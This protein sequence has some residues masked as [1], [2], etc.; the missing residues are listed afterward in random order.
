[1]AAA[2]A[3]PVSPAAPATAAWPA[4]SA[5][6]AAAATAA[7]VA[8]AVRRRRRRRRR[9]VPR[10]GR[11]QPG[12]H[13]RL[14]PRQRLG[15]DRPRAACYRPRAGQPRPVRYRPR[16]PARA[17]PPPALSRAPARRRARPQPPRQ[18]IAG[19]WA[20]CG[21][22]LR[23]KESPANRS[24]RSGGSTLGRRRH[25]TRPWTRCRPGELRAASIRPP[26]RRR[27]RSRGR[28][29]ARPSAG[30]LEAEQAGQLERVALGLVLDAFH[31]PG[32]VAHADR[33][34]RRTYRP[35]PLPRLCL[36]R[37][38]ICRFC[39]LRVSA[40]IRALAQSY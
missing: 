32:H 18:R 28:R 12:A 16:R 9:L 23:Q 22:G 40:D 1:M 26:R 29:A 8:A 38:A 17:A 6:V 27:A 34:R 20:R 2:A 11:D 19:T 31:D 25:F 39:S 21:C 7:A 30:G 3:T 14:Q 36:A 5:V 10:A 33:S 37:L 35:K 15:H 13:G 4:A 24:N